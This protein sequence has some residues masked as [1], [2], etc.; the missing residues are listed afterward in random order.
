MQSGRRFALLPESSSSS[1]FSSSPS[2]LSSSSSPSPPRATLSSRTTHLTLSRAL[3]HERTRAHRRQRARLAH[4]LG[5]LAERFRASPSS[6][7]SIV[8]SATSLLADPVHTVRA[9]AAEQA[10][11]LLD[12]VVAANAATPS[13]AGLVDELAALRPT[14]MARVAAAVVVGH[15]DAD[16]DA[17]AGGSLVRSLLELASSPL[18]ESRL[19]LHATFLLV[20]P[21]SWPSSVATAAAT[22]HKTL[23]A[24]ASLAT[25]I[26]STD[27]A[28]ALLFGRPTAYGGLTPTLVTD[29]ALDHEHVS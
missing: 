20:P 11:A 18:R 16:V 13:A 27:D 24:D 5:P 10:S 7:T 26:A 25:T 9:A 28:H 22:A 14:V 12:V 3:S 23:A 6:L 29:H 2:S 4:Q 8:G 21:S 1:S 19:L 17:A 15:R